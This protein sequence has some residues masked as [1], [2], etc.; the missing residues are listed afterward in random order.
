[1]DNAVRDLTGEISGVLA[2]GAS[3]TIAEYLLPA[4]LGAFKATIETEI[5]KELEKKK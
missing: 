2:I 3:T 1:M 5:Q 4:M